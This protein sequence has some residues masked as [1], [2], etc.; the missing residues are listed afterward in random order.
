MRALFCNSCDFIIISKEKKK[1]DTSQK[2]EQN[3]E[4]GRSAPPPTRRPLPGRAGAVHERCPRCCP[5]RCPWALST[6]L[7]T[8][9]S[10]GA[11]RGAA[12]PA[13][14][15]G[16]TRLPPAHTPRP[17]ARPQT[18]WAAA[19]AHRPTPWRGRTRGSDGLQRGE[20]LHTPS[21][22]RA[23]RRDVTAGTMAGD[24]E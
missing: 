4:A 7:S 13:A 3:G 6:V 9:L 10:A 15:Q 22:L 19:S 8:A 23:Q 17:A 21:P 12:S 5:R 20:G 1:C 16:P 14:E 11:V 2:V 24:T 18:P